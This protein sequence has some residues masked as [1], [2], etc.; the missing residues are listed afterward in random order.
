MPMVLM[1]KTKFRII[2]TCLIL[3]FAGTFCNRANTPPTDTGQQR[4]KTFMMIHAEV[5]EA[6]YPWYQEIVTGA[7][8]L[9]LKYQEALWPSLRSLVA[10]AD[11]YNFKLTIALN[12][13]WAEYILAS[14]ERTATA[15]SWLSNGHEIAFHHHG[16]DHPDWSGFSNRTN[17]A[18]CGCCFD[19][20]GFPYLGVPGCPTQAYRGTANDGF[21]FVSQLASPGKVIT[22]AV[23]DAAYDLPADISV[24]TVGIDVTSARSIP[25]VITLQD[26]RTITRLGHGFLDSLATEDPLLSFEAEY[27]KTASSEVFGTVTHVHDYWRKPEMITSWFDFVKSGGD[28]IR[29]VGYFAN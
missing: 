20:P 22:G 23:T 29:T 26:G 14:A 16:C 5:G 21:S 1:K 25:T 28:I 27:D 17:L 10:L 9:N 8:N 2:L 6:Q 3:V 24:G 19:P 4:T 12:P 11:S 13:Q 15:R 18:E 7:D